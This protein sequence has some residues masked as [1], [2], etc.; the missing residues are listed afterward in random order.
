[1]SPLFL[2]FLLN[3]LV[4]GLNEIQYYA[5]VKKEIIKIVNKSV[6]KN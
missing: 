6:D 4:S 1:M 2:V 3:W 5:L